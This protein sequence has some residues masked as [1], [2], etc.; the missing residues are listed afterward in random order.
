MRGLGSRWAVAASVML[1][2]QS[3]ALSAQVHFALDPR[4]SLAW[5]QIRPHFRHLW[6]TT[7]PQE[8]SWRPGELFSP[9][10]IPKF[11]LEDDTVV[12]L[13][14]RNIAKKVCTE[15]IHGDV[16]VADTTHWRGVHGLVVIQAAELVTGLEFR[17]TYTR[18]RILET[19]V[20]PEIRFVIDSVVNV[21]LG[22]TLLA[23][24]V[25]VLELHG[26]RRAWT[27]PIRAWHEPLGFR[28][29]GQF[30]FPAPDLTDVY[31]L[32]RYALALGVRT[33]IWKR[34]F[35]GIDA[36]LAPESGTAYRP[37]Q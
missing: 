5:W 31:H 33:D 26:V 18:E 19:T 21:Q 14:P 10:F 4:S 9:G 7:C 27:V 15:A 11:S 22:D 34:F 20:Y 17:D 1:L 25:G 16:T 3:G 30:E 6:A 35:L 32:S 29:T 8:R 13:Y 12:P 23:D 37:S 24:A 28:V 2:A 36:V